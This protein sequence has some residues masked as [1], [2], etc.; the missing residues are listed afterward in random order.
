MGT[1]TAEQAQS[2]LDRW[3]LV[4]E[5]EVHGL[6][7]SSFDIKARQLSVLM[8]SR[9]L[10]AEDNHRKKEVDVVRERW[11]QIRGALRG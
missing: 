10:F 4:H 11:T 9:E 5:V 2:Y 7:N 3:K 8:A 1:I 6:R